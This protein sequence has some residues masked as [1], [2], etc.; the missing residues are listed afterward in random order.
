MKICTGHPAGGPGSGNQ[1]LFKEEG[2]C[3]RLPAGRPRI[4]CDKPCQ[5]QHTTPFFKGEIGY[6]ARL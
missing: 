2:Y 1:Y 3:S 5:S 4:H 6:R